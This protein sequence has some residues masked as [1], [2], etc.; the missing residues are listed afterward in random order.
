VSRVTVLVVGTVEFEPLVI[1]SG[2][3]SD[4]HFTFAVISQWTLHNSDPFASS[5]VVI[6]GAMQLPEANVGLKLLMSQSLHQAALLHQFLHERVNFVIDLC[7]F[8]Y[9]IRGCFPP[10]D[11]SVL[12][13]RMVLSLLARRLVE[14]FLNIGIRIGFGSFSIRTCTAGP[15]IANGFRLHSK[16]GWRRGNL[17]LL[18]RSTRHWQSI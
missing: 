7:G 11:L 1:W 5:R 18:I 10:H 6:L 9:G 16:A 12:E 13:V 14:L 3:D 4:L 17:I 15:V 8:Q 2:D